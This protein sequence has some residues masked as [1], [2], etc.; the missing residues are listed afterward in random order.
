MFFNKSKYQA[1]LIR[2]KLIKRFNV[3]NDILKN[4]EVPDSLTDREIIAIRNTLLDRLY[5]STINSLI[6]NVEEFEEVVC[7]YKLKVLKEGVLSKGADGYP[8][9]QGPM[10][11]TGEPGESA[12]EIAVRHGFEG[13]EEEWIKLLK[14][15]QKEFTIKELD[16]GSNIPITD[17]SFNKTEKNINYNEVENINKL[18]EKGEFGYIYKVCGIDYYWNG[19]GYSQ[20]K[21]IKIIPTENIIPDEHGEK[22]L[23]ETYV[24]DIITINKLPE[25]PDPLTAYLLY[26]NIYYRSNG[27][28]SIIGR[29]I[30]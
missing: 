5:T 2:K 25:K 7:N 16:L 22:V 13:T 9:M 17:G 15:E 23:F 20:V 4:M 19:K 3:A 26:G 21:Y 12:Y 29:T 24:K 14:P 30:S 18:P 10:G 6:E 11:M 27:I 8:G 28:W 1:K